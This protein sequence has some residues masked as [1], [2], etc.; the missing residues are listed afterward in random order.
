MI[1]KPYFYCILT[2]CYIATL[3]TSKKSHTHTLKR[4][5]T[6]ESCRNITSLDDSGLDSVRNPSWD[7]TGIR[8]LGPFLTFSV[9]LLQLRL[10]HIH[11]VAVES[12]H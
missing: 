2:T 6:F 1:S 3:W 5:F 4:H 9:L 11:Q 7:K 12:V 10:Y 8:Q